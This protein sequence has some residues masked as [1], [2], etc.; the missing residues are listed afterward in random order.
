MNHK[1]E[2]EDSETAAS[3]VGD[4]QLKNNMNQLTNKKLI[5]V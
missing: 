1:C 4:G 5:E 3:Y 2:M